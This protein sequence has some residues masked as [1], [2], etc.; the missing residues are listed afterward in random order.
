MIHTHSFDPA[1]NADEST[2]AL[3]NF[4]N[5]IILIDDKVVKISA[6]LLRPSCSGSS[7]LAPASINQ[8]PGN[9]SVIYICEL[10]EIKAKFDPAK[11]KDLG[12]NPVPNYREL[13]LGNSVH[14][15]DVLGPSIPGPIVL[16]IDCPTLSHLKNME[17]PILKASVRLTARLNYL[18]PQPAPGFWSLPN[19]NNFKPESISSTEGS[20]SKLNE[21]I[22]VKNLLKFHFRS[23]AQPGV[24]KSGIPSLSTP[25]EIVDELLFEIPEI[26]DSLHQI[27]QLWHEK[28]E[29]N[30]A[31]KRESIVM[32]EEPWLN[33]N[34]MNLV[35]QSTGASID[36]TSYL[37]SEAGL[38]TCLENVTREDMEIVLRGT[39]SSQPSKYQN[40]ATKLEVFPGSEFRVTYEEALKYGGKVILAKGSRK[41]YYG[42]APSVLVLLPTRELPKQVYAEFEV[43]GGS[44]NL[45]GCCLYGGAPYHSQETSLKRG[46]DISI[47]TPGRIKDHIER[48]NLNFS[49]LKFGVLDEADKILKMGFVDDVELI[50][51]KVK[52]VTKV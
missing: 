18:C 31:D 4:T 26:V 5:P 23:Y 30:N 45:T 21:S 19:F 39:G 3:V 27:N 2:L 47:G 6:I 51:G 41:T 36:G 49:S 12:L 17:I 9:I 40:V 16:L 20:F 11:A 24:D 22:S 46:V 52:D 43:Y 37:D 38:P 10:S 15:T 25:T 29:T 28:S 33:E 42:R 50:L 48:G 7:H 34:T 32:I 13:Q 1:P 8:K 44:L 35:E 14:P